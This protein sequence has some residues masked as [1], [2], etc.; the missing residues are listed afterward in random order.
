M[1]IRFSNLLILS[2]SLFFVSCL[3]MSGEFGWAL[4]DESKQGQLEK[5]FFNVQE[6]TLTRE[7][8]IFPTDKTLVYLYKFSRMPNPEAEIYV[9]LSRFQ[10]GFNEIEVKR[11]R[12]EISSSSITGSFQ[13]LISG[14]YLMKVS[15]E[16]EVIDNVEFRVIEP[17]GKEEEKE[18]GI[19][20]IDKYT[21]AKKVLN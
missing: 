16:G 5:K 10:V 15:Y 14:K 11:K 18:S 12:P 9:S 1:K 4:V 7:K 3:G 17:E 6:F 2:Y 21:K 20:D 8:L 19:D 13:E